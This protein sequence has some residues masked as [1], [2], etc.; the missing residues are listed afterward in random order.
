MAEQK[1]KQQQ[2]ES[3]ADI[4][5]SVFKEGILSGDPLN[6]DELEEV[7]EE[8][9]EKEEKP[10]EEKEE[11][12]TQ[13]PKKKQ[14]KDESQ[15]EKKKKSK[16]EEDD[17]EE[18]EFEDIEEDLFAEE[19]EDASTTKYVGEVLD[20]ILDE[21]E[22]SGFL[23]HYSISE[24]EEVSLKDIIDLMKLE[25]EEKAK[26]RVLDFVQALPDDLKIA[27]QYVLNGKSMV[28]FIKD[29]EKI[30]SEPQFSIDKEKDKE[31]FIKWWLTTKEGYD[32]DDAEDFISNLKEK[33]KLDK[34][35]KTKY[36]IY[37]KDL[38]AK[39]KELEE[40]ALREQQEQQRKL[41][42]QKEIMAELLES[43]HEIDGITIE[44]REK[45]KILSAIFDLTEDVGG[46]K[47]TL[48]QKKMAE[49][50]NDRKK[51]ILLTKLLL[52]DFNLKP[53]FAESERRLIRKMSGEEPARKQE[54]KPRNRSK[55]VSQ[56]RPLAEILEEILS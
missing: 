11:E 36:E 3:L 2:E 33:G 28:D 20:M 43:V 18:E 13:E 54:F 17:D 38:E 30:V 29:Y 9:A 12:E 39:K 50:L 27:M 23:E 5:G 46:Q 7:V 45:Q 10:T 8:G 25:A 42:E 26:K 44:E 35:A 56:P 22:G 53:F 41:Q 47:V 37:K 4:L 16:K 48:F 40:R 52:E 32:S 49:V 55:T 19:E 34:Y 15:Q 31:E 21:L 51:L 1:K 24:D 14:E 6:F